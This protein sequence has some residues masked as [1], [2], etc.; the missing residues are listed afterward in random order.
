MSGYRQG[1]AYPG[2]R[3]IDLTPKIAI[4]ATELPGDFHKDPADRLI[5]ATARV[6]DCRLLTVDTQILNYP[7]V[8]TF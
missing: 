5:V 7:H 1:L 3:L 6:H 4:E 2:I 8:K